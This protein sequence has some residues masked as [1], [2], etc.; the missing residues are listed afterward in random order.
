MISFFTR[1]GGAGIIR[2]EQVASYL[3][4]KL[5]PLSDFENDV[6]V[7]I[8]CVPPENYPKKTYI[9]VVEDSEGLR[10]VKD[11]PDVGIIASSKSIYEHFDGILTNHLVF[12]PQHHCNFEKVVR[13][14]D[15]VE[16]AGIIGNKAAFQHPLED[17]EK[18]LNKIGIELKTLIQ[19]RFDSREEV[20]EFYKQIDIQIIWRPNSDGIIR[21]PLKLTNACSFGIPTVAYPEENFMAEYESYFIPVTTIDEMIEKIKQLKDERDYYD[22]YAFAGLFKA[23]TYHISNIAKLYLTL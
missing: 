7:Y 3:G 8:K 13:T 18:K 6:C 15:K 11:H 17:L 23:E 4:A 1:S 20:V 2:G 22:N 9:D 19:K 21:N 12:I 14:R 16:I 10:W 5:N